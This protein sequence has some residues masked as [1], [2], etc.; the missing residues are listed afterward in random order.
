QEEER[1]VDRDAEE[2]HEE[3][4]DDARPAHALRGAPVRALEEE[5]H[6]EPERGARHDGPQQDEGTQRDEREEDEE[7][8]RGAPSARLVLVHAPSGRFRTDG[9]FAYFAFAWRRFSKAV[10]VSRN[11]CAVALCAWPHT[12]GTPSCA[13]CCTAGSSGIEPKRSM[14]CAAASFAPP[15]SPKMGVGLSQCGHTNVPM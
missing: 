4:R 15:C 11:A 10:I 8:A 3:D 2:D 1:H 14:P 9:A 5:A 12:K 7:E 6:D 13:L